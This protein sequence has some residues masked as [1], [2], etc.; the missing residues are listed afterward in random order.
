MMSLGLPPNPPNPPELNP[1]RV[2]REPRAEVVF[3]T[4]DGPG[5]RRGE[6]GG[7]ASRSEAEMGPPAA[8]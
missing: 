2:D 5:A 8:V 4:A 1:P 6:A 7:A 3:V